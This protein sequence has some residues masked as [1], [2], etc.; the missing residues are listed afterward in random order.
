LTLNQRADENQNEEIQKVLNRL[1]N[2][3]ERGNVN[4]LI[5]GAQLAVLASLA[6]DKGR[7]S[8]ALNLYDKIYKRAP[9][10]LS[11]S[12]L[13]FQMAEVY[14]K[15]GRFNEARV[16]YEQFLESFANSIPHWIVKIRLIQLQSFERPQ[17]ALD[18][19]II[20]KDKELV[21]REGRQ[22]ASLTSINLER[23]NVAQNKEKR[24]KEIAQDNTSA[25][26]F[27]ELRM[28]QARLALEKKEFKRAF[29]FAQELWLKYPNSSLLKDS[30]LF[31]R[32]LFLIEVD[33]LLKYEPKSIDDRP[34]EDAYIDVILLYFSE[35]EWFQK[36]EMAALFYLMVGRAMRNMGM[37]EEAIRVV[38]YGLGKSASKSKVQALLQ[39]ELTSLYREKLQKKEYEKETERNLA[40]KFDLTIKYLDKTF[41]N[42]FDT[43]DYWAARGYHFERKQRWKE[44]KEVYL[45]ALNGESMSPYELISLAQAIYKIYVKNKDYDKAVNALDEILKIYNEYARELNQ[46]GF[47]S[48][49]LWNKFEMNV[50]RQDWGQTILSLKNYLKASRNN[51]SSN[52]QNIVGK[53]PTNQFMDSQEFSLLGNMAVNRNEEALFYLGY[54][55]LKLNM[56]QEAKKNNG[57]FFTKSLQGAYM[58]CLLKEN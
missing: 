25:Y 19:L 5:I 7:Y 58:V 48:D 38:N 10:V 35:I 56:I 8:E 45:Y 27:Q 51:M 49:I 52:F 37:Y 43:F 12:N 20:L 34:I 11:N 2:I 24:L 3:S 9:S 26:V 14:F 22:Y 4:D 44:A 29:L 15:L 47:K 36:S 57:I 53:S 28:Q 42:Y 31:F 39:L 50:E 54:A 30:R 6:Y 18:D 46:P 33:R 32:R 17:G 21:N 16:A 23:D 55:Y 41:P 1:D 13:L 40:T